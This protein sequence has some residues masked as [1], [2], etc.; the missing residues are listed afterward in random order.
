MS[1]VTGPGNSGD[2]DFSLCQA[3]TAGTFLLSKLYQN[4]AKVPA[5]KCEITQAILV[6]ESKAPQF[7]GTAW[8]MLR[9]QHGP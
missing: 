6:L 4:P 9:S 8:M 2:F 1:F 7:H 3:S 5:E